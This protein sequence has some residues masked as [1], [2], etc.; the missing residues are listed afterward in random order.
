MPWENGNKYGSFKK[1][2][3]PEEELKKESV[4]LGAK[5][6]ELENLFKE[7]SISHASL[8]FK[9]ILC[10]ME[11]RLGNKAFLKMGT[12]LA[13]PEN[14]ILFLESVRF[15]GM[16]D[17]VRGALYY[18]MRGDW[19]IVLTE[20]HP[21]GKEMLYAQSLG[22][23]LTTIDWDACKS[24]T[25]VE[26]K[27][28]AFEHLLHDLAHAYMFFRED[29]DYPGQV[30][31]FQTMYEDFSIYEPFLESNKEFKKKFEYCISDMNS[32]PA[33]LSAYWNAIQKEE[34]IN[35]HR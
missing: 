33:H 8:C 14:E 22:Y 28:D 26:G 2:L 1:I 25:L 34:G 27:R 7:N 21:S 5:F 10:Y 12:P 13:N 17:T 18:W 19:K 30:K 4:L 9:F 16:P 3:I 15:Y 31:F 20:T 11:S 35:I 32:H 24:G 29:Y 6:I 23:R